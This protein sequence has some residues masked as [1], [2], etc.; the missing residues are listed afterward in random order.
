[1]GTPVMGFGISQ[2]PVLQYRGLCS[3]RIRR[4]QEETDSSHVV[5]MNAGDVETIAYLD[6]AWARS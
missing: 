2:M 1:M 3:L 6:W 5:F 4:L